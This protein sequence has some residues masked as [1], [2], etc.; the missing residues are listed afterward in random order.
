[1][2]QPN[3]F[4]RFISDHELKTLT[5]QAQSKQ[6]ATDRRLRKVLEAAFSATQFLD[7]RSGRGVAN[8]PAAPSSRFLK[9][10]GS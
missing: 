4:L 7:W 9:Q 3:H 8:M 2:T 6:G 5:S 1:M 10:V